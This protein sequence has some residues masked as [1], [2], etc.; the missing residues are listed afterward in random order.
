LQNLKDYARLN[1]LHVA[2]AAFLIVV[3]IYAAFTDHHSADLLV[4]AFVAFN[5]FDAAKI[6]RLELALAEATSAA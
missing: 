1:P 6:Q 3:E 2:V 4:A 5:V